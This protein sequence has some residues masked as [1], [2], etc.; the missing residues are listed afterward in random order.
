M[1]MTVQQEHPRHR[2]RCRLGGWPHHRGRPPRRQAGGRGLG[3][4]GGQLLGI[5]IGGCLCNDLRYVAAEM[6]IRIATIAVDVVVTFGGEPLVA[7]EASV[8]VVVTT[9]DPNAD[10]DGL[11]D[12]ARRTSTV[13]N[14]TS[15]GVP[16]TITREA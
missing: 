9:E 10:I 16:V 3:F 7:T 1:D 15:R 4:N 12:P 11:I 2:G 13:S 8:D 14:S 5:A 6:G